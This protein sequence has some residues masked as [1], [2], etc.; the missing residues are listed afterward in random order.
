MEGFSE[1]LQISFHR[2]RERERERGRE[3]FSEILQFFF[4][5]NF[6]KFALNFL[7]LDQLGGTLI[8]FA[9]QLP[10][11]LCPIHFF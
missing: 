7:I 9:S 10:S 8:S 11:H 1:I 4:S 3:G 6:L 2:K 5:R